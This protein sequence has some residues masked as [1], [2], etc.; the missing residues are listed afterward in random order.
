MDIACMDANLKSNSPKAIANRPIKCD[1]SM[2]PLHADT[3]T[4]I[5]AL[6]DAAL[7]VAPP[8]ETGRGIGTEH[9]DVGA[10]VLAVAAE[11]ATRNANDERSDDA[12]AKKD[13]ECS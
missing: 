8:T 10:V 9:L 11:A 13:G 5:G 3:T 4:E 2:E 1:R 12:A 7:A 6:D